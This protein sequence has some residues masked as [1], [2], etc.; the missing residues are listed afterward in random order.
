[1]DVFECR[2]KNSFINLFAIISVTHA[3][4]L[5]IIAETE[6]ESFELKRKKN[7]RNNLFFFYVFDKNYPMHNVSLS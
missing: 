2:I 5:Y 3:V 4:C 1:M 6:F 7:R